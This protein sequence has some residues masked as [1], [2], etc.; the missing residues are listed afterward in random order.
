MTTPDRTDTDTDGGAD[1]DSGD[2]GVRRF[3]G[4]QATNDPAR[5]VLPVTDGIC[6]GRGALYGGCG[7]AAVIEAAE[8]SVG[9]PTAWGTL[10]FAS[11]ARPPAQLTLDVE[12]LAGGRRMSQVRVSG[13]ADGELVMAAL[14]A[15]GRRE[16][17]AEGYWERMPAVPSPADC[18]SRKL[19]NEERRGGLRS[20]IDERTATTGP[21]GLL[22]AEGGRSALWVTMTGGVPA[23]A[24]ALALLGDDVSAGVAAAVGDDVRARSIDNT[25]RV[26]Q[27]R[28]TPWVLAD[29]QVHAVVDGLG[30]GSV[31]LWSEDGHLLAVTGQTGLV[32][33]R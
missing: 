4:L 26:V 21:D 30:H 23:S 2:D 17:V 10:Q 3:L 7:L 8:G 33:P 19:V 25:I 1:S 31:N 32:G 29:V 27:P 12:V 24:S 15:L 5:W 6:G 11:G 9:R 13:H 28:S 18:P 22:T 16:Q 14:L 20:R